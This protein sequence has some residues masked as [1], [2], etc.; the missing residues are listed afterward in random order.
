MPQHIRLERAGARRPSRE[1]A[2][3]GY[4]VH[5]GLMSPRQ[6]MVSQREQGRAIQ[7]APREAS[8]HRI[9]EDLYASAK[10][11]RILPL[12]SAGVCKILPGR[13]N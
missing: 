2:W 6:P 5:T 1:L 3:V 9:L 10:M 11:A 13:E 7:A 8:Q 12:L 4:K